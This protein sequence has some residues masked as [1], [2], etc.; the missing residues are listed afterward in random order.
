MEEADFHNKFYAA[1]KITHRREE[2][3]A[4][5]IMQER[6]R[7]NPKIEFLFNTT[8]EEVIGTREEGVKA[9][10]LKNVRT[11][12]SSHFPTQ[13]LFVAIGHTPN[14]SAY[15]GLLTLDGRGYITLPHAHPTVTNVQGVFACGDAVHHIHR[16]SVTAAGSGCHAALDCTRWLPHERL[17]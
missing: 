17:T 2:M 4:S 16:Q 12:E 8:V 6:A 3:R 7:A 13:G 1:G 15:S 9:V 10:R 11:G 5:K 14:T